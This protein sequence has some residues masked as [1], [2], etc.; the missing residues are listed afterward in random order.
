MLQHLIYTQIYIALKKMAAFREKNFFQ[1][2]N[3]TM[4]TLL[5][6]KTAAKDIWRIFGGEKSSISRKKA[7]DYF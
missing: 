3:F 2:C 1:K 6:L 5:G 7:N 4:K